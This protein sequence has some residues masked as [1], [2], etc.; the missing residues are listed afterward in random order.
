M[1]R[2]AG[3]TKYLLGHSRPVEPV[4]SGA[5]YAAESGDPEPI[6]GF[7]LELAPRVGGSGNERRGCQPFSAQIE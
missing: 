5:G 6:T 1:K 7:P 2:S 4:A 3:L